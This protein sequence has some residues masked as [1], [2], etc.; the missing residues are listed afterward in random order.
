MVNASVPIQVGDL[1]TWGSIA[2]D[3]SGYTTH[4]VTTDG[5]LFGWGQNSDYGNLGNGSHN[6]PPRAS[7]PIQIGALTNWSTE[8][9]HMAKGDGNTCAIKQD[10]TMWSWGGS[11]HFGMC[12]DGTVI[13]RSSPVQIGS[14]TNWTFVVPHFFGFTA[15]KSTG[16]LYSWG[17]N[18]FGQAGQG[19]IGAASVS[20]SVN[21]VPTQI[22]TD[23]DWENL[24]GENRVVGAVK[25]NG[26]LYMWGEGTD[27]RTGS[28]AKLHLSLP[29]QIGALTTWS[30]ILVRQN[31][32]IAK[33]TDGTIWAWGGT[34]S[35]S[36]GDGTIIARSSPVQIATDD[37]WGQ[38]AG[39]NNN[40]FMLKSL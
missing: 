27:G 23:T 38:I 12:G 25:T 19:G 5:K 33:K 24:G 35:R 14:D 4:A 15:L 26:K 6:A 37:G 9:G 17:N 18:A 16:A 13:N 28:G 40:L 1:E 3:V 31:V 29:T 21:S 7:S 36:V 30:E 20:G 2:G 8:I 34:Y 10:G 11:N 39:Y 22:G 32:T